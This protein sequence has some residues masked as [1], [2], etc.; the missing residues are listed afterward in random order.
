[1]VSFRL[2]TPTMESVSMGIRRTYFGNMAAFVET[3][4][5]QYA[6]AY[7]YAKE[8]MPIWSTALTSAPDGIKRAAETYPPFLHY[9][10]SGMKS[11][12]EQEQGYFIRIRH[13]SSDTTAIAEVYSPEPKV[14]SVQLADLTP[15]YCCRDIVNELNR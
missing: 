13:F 9:Q 14:I 3:M 4:L 15:I 5:M 2:D 12:T 6:S 11:H 1:M 7:D 8:S 10:F